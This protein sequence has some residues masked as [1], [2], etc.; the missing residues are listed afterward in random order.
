[1]FY[2]L[3]ELQLAVQNNWYDIKYPFNKSYINKNYYVKEYEK[4]SS[5]YINFIKKKITDKDDRCP[6]YVLFDNTYHTRLEKKWYHFFYFH[7]IK[8]SISLCHS[9]IFH[10]YFKL[11]E[12]QNRNYP[13]NTFYFILYI[14]SDKLK[15]YTDRDIQTI[16]FYFWHVLQTHT[17]QHSI[18]LSCYFVINEKK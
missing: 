13:K 4:Y 6:S 7:G 10:K 14:T 16:Q 18:D 3:H 2:S 1:M 11:S 9:E 17:L 5:I 8:K 15:N 12:N